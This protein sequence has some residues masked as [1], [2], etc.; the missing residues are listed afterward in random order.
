MC[1]VYRSKTVF[2]KIKLKKKCKNAWE[3]KKVRKEKKTKKSLKQGN[4]PNLLLFA[5]FMSTDIKDK[6][7][8]KRWRKSKKVR[9]KKKQARNH[10]ILKQVKQ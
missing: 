5:L 2:V 3:R 10:N 8:W 9:V 1:D 6:K 4:L 7:S